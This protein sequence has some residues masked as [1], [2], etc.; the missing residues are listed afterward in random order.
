MVPGDFLS[1]PLPYPKS[2]R[3]DSHTRY[4]AAE[5]GAGATDEARAAI[6]VALGWVDACL[7]YPFNLS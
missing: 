1:L 5:N 3:A 2:G 4:E 7:G 6:S